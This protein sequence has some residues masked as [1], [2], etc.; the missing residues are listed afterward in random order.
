VERHPEQAASLISLGRTIEKRGEVDAAA[1]LYE[2]AIAAADADGHALYGSLARTNYGRLR[3]ER[4]GDPDGA[5]GYLAEAAELFATEDVWLVTGLVHARQRSYPRAI[6]AFE[7]GLELAPDSYG[8][9]LAISGALA[10]L[11][12]FDEALAHLDR[13]AEV[14]GG[15]PE[16]LAE[17]KRRRDLLLRIRSQLEEGR[18]GATRSR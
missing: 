3:D 2:R 13:C 1:A 7:K 18:R 17:V 11:G 12:R 6:A 5:L 8:I 10:A 4:F 14:A 15:S 9:H 16:A